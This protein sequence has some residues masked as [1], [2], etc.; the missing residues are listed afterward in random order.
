MESSKEN[1]IVDLSFEFAKRIVSLHRYLQNEKKEF[2]LSKQVLRAGTSIGAN[3]NEAQAAQSPKDF[4]AK[5]SVASKEARETL[6]WLRL[7]SET[8]YLDASQPHV[9][10]LL[11]ES[12]SIIKILTSIILTSQE[13]L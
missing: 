11:D 7:L 9:S 12:R 1:L 4:I 5:L 2:V 10:S 6:Y 13:K 8:G 3:V